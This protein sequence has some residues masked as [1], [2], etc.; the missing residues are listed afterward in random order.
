MFDDALKPLSAKLFDYNAAVHLLNR[1]GFGGT[2]AQAR[3]LADMGLNKAVDQL[4]KYESQPVEPV[5]ADLFDNGIMSPP[6]DEQRETAKK[7]RQSNDENALAALQR[8][9]Q[10]KQSDDRKQ[11]AELQ[12]WWIKRMI[13]TPRPLEEKMTLFYHGHFATGYRTIEDS[14]HM[15]QQNQLFRKFATGNFAQLAHRIIRDPAM[16][17][18]LDNDENQKSKPNENMARELMELFTLGEGRGYTE[19][20]IKAGALAL[21][22]YT[23]KDD[24]FYFNNNNHDA[25]TKNIMGQ[26]GPFDGDGFL[27]VILARNECA[28]FMAG[29]LFKFFVNDLPGEPSKEQKAFI[30]AMANKL[31]ASKFEVKPLLNAVFS[32]AYFYSADN[33]GAII[34]SPI[35]LTVQAV[36]S[37]RTPVR[38]L[39]ALASAT[40]LMGQN[41]FFP[42]NVKGWD[43]GRSWMNTSTL[44]IRQNL[45]VY[46][47]TGRKPDMYEWQASDIPFDATHL[48]DHLR[49]P[50]GSVDMA[51][52]IE[53]LLRFNLAQSP[54]PLRLQQVMAFATSRGAR[55]D[56]D[57]IIAVLALTTA[58]P[59]Y[60]LC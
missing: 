28:E 50:D 22:G 33:R 47:L 12:K 35:Q 37:L 41:V 4:V 40:D 56:N 13:E 44:F 55:L 52:G 46:L 16:L 54:S 36:R 3:A 24:T 21:T 49:Q 1:A 6:T 48:V 29:K 2:P 14:F 17:K 10:R 34:K 53:Y 30:V 31:R 25:S 43:G 9:R 5:K 15:Y 59:E 26:S 60:Q 51:S 45:L 38:E 57:R 20:D 58:M 8:E 11:I 39:S 42:P 19:D 27:D 23:F 18:Y 7:A 32:S